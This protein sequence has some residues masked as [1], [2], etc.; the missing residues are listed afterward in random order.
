MQG[1]LVLPLVAL[2]LVG[3]VASGFFLLREHT[4]TDRLVLASGSKT[5]EYYAFSQAFAEVVTRNH[6]T[7]EIDVR[8][9]NG[10]VQNM[11]LLR[12]RQAQLALVQSDTPVQPPV[13]AVALLFP[14]MFHL[15]ARTDV[16]IETV[17]DLR[18]KRIALMPE[19]SG[20]Y[21]LFWPLVEHYGLTPETLTTL[22]MTAAQAH[23]SL[24]QGEVDALFRVITLGNA[25]VA[26]LLQTGTTRLLPIDQVDALRLSLPYLNA[27][28][29]PKGTYNGGIPI[30]ATD[31]PVVAV[32]ALLVAHE[33]LP[34]RVVNALTSTLHQNRNELVA[35]YPRAAMI[36]LDASR[37]LGL[38]LHPGAEAFYTQGEPEFLVEYAEPIGLLLSVLV[39]SFSSLW[40]L[41]SWLLGKQKNRADTYNLEILALM[42]RI[43]QAQSLEELAALRKTLLDILQQVVTDLDVDRITSESFESFTF[44]WEVANNAIRH[45][46]MLL[47][48]HDGSRR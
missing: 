10:S 14:E 23:A 17:V 1:K 31:L 40:Q 38:P 43:D 34:P 2:S 18:G 36:R 39:L 12:T 22:P 28:V 21:A 48:G 24:E 4:R 29:I 3:A 26:D 37:D 33:E 45:Q 7:I 8:E 6:P 27:Q 9:T 32:N 25:A 35:L 30:P 15:L 46:E 19:G 47:R 20:S 13:R 11:D 5:G 42:D 44:P 16:E 41:R